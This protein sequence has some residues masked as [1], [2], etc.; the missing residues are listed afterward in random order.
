MTS[1][2]CAE[3]DQANPND[4]K[5]CVHCGA[6]LSPPSGQLTSA[7]VILWTGRRGRQYAHLF[8]HLFPRREISFKPSWS[9]AAALVPFWM[10]YRRLYLEWL[11]F[12]AV[13]FFLGLTGVPFWP[14]TFIVQGLFGNALY[15]LALERRARREAETRAE[16][17]A[18]QYG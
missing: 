14:L 15:F 9:W 7:L 11:L 18:H 10:I 13:D 4:G 8:E 2:Q 5:Y 3:C 6:K 1:R 12:F 17:E 16:I